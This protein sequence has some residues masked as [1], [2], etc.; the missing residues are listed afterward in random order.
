MLRACRRVLKRGGRLAF[1]VIA[2]RPGLSADRHDFA[3]DAVPGF[4]ETSAP[5]SELLA[6]AGFASITEED[7][8]AGYHTTA[9]LWLRE[10][11]AL[12]PELRA[13]LGDTVYETKQVNRRSSFAAIEAGT[14][15]RLLY[16]AE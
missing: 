7:V 5:Y 4:V 12:E 13:A 15:V 11:A 6:T 10:S 1:F 9:A 14:L 3:K 8:T 2:I 16:T